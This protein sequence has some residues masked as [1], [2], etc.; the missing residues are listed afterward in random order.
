[1]SRKFRFSLFSL[2]V[3][4][5]VV[6]AACAPTAD[7]QPQQVIVV[8]AT[9]QPQSTP[10]P[11]VSS[12]WQLADPPA[13]SWFTLPHDLDASIVYQQ[14]PVDCS[15]ANDVNETCSTK[16]GQATSGDA[17][18]KSRTALVMTGDQ[19]SL[20]YQGSVLAMRPH[21]SVAHDLWVLL[22]A[23]SEDVKVNMS[24]PN[25]SFR[26]YFTAE[27]WTPAMLAHLRDLHLERFLEPLEPNS[28]TPTP[29][30]NCGEEYEACP[31]TNV[32]VLVYEG[33]VWIESSIG[34]Y[35]EWSIQWWEPAR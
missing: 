10:Q 27:E 28:Y 22:N 19:I 11:V 21:P 7:P 18:L 34:F 29:V 35:K 2:F 4:I 13:P 15:V 3:L 6:M 8:T 32:R 33:G 30:A 31:K 20:S 1:M 5:A 12:G 14:P 23:S 26:G 9:S 25:G 16:E 24:A 17:T